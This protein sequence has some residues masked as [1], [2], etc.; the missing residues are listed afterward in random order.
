MPFPKF[1]RI[2]VLVWLAGLC[3]R[4]AMGQ[5]AERQSA[6]GSMLVEGT[7]YDGSQ[8]IGLPGV[9]V[10]GVSGIGTATDSLGHYHIRLSSGDSIYFSYLGR[11]T[12]RFPVKLVT[13]GQPFDMGLDVAP[14]SLPEIFVQSRNYLMDSLATRRDYKKIFDYE[15]DYLTNM[16]SPM[17]GRGMGIGLD[18]DMLLDG[19]KVRRMEA[20][21]QRLEWEER[22][23]Y[24]DHR[25]T[26]NLVTKITGIEPPALD[27]FMRLYRPSYE[28]LQT[29]ETEY[30]FDKYIHDCGKA[31]QVNVP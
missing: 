8:R 12:A 20:F 6:A 2:T 28:F 3:G 25:F 1:L 16:K 17:R 7:V 9:S 26:R 18:L 15:P 23:N 4:T 11:T 19:R 30:E 22:E 27:S 24:V 21:Q 10:M 29:F 5:T 14:E 13:A 31:Y